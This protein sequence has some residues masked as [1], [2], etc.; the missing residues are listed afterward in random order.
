MHTHARTTARTTARTHARTHTH[1]H[2]HTVQ[3]D[4]G[5]EQYFAIIIIIPSYITIMGEQAAL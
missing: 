3:I 1:T 4:R 2:T 5:E